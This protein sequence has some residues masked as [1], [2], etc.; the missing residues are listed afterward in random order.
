MTMRRN[1]FDR[2]PVDTEPGEPEPGEPDS[3]DGFSRSR[4]RFETVLAWLG[5]E[6]AGGLTHG[7][8]ETRLSEDHR[9]LF[10]LL[11]Q[12]HLDLRALREARLTGVRDTD[13]EDRSSAEPGHKRGLGTIFGEVVVQ[14]MAYRRRGLRNLYPADAGLNLPTEKHSHG[15]RRLAAIEAS[16]GS[17][18]DAV[19]AIERSTG[20]Q[21]GKRQ[22][23]D[24]TA[25]AAVDFDT[26]YTTRRP[27][28]GQASDVL[29]LSCDG[30]GVVM[31]P[32]A[33]RAATRRA[34]TRTTTKLATRLSKGEKR[35]R[36]RIAEVGAVYDATPVPRTPVD[37]LPTTDAERRAATPGPRARDKWLTASVVDDAA[38]V[39]AQI[40][41]EAERRNPDHARTW[42]ALVDGNNHQIDR[43]HAEARTRNV[44]VDIIIDFVHVLEYIWKAAWCLH[45]EG[46]P[47]AEAWVRRHA[48]T[49]LNGGATRVASTIRR[50]ATR[51]RLAPAKRAGVDTC[52]T[53]LTNKR[54][55]LDYPTALEQGWPIAT[56]IIEGAC[57]HLVKDRLDLTGARWG[58]DGAEA[59]LKLRALHSNGDFDAYWHY[60]LTRERERVHASRYHNNAIPQAA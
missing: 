36:K 45:T 42:I 27:P 26:F 21:L 59:I 22:V 10:R 9:E 34:A 3:G 13:G 17:F 48:G 5:G 55:H 44:P 33:L 19:A 23:E 40:F 41:D 32:D 12:D 11:V 20:Q 16:R 38:T 15:L 39:V 7:E 29:V 51:A 6:E 28:Q 58:L 47:T 43:I 50:A 24:L 56:G 18:D 8:L 30:K 2:D 31:R 4:D 52:A 37:I 49:I 53:Y 46:D 57:R 1:A 54:D 25:R 14:R 35:N 60:H